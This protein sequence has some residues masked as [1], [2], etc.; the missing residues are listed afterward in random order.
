M[1][2]ALERGVGVPGRG[3]LEY[4]E[5]G[6]GVPRRGGLEYLGLQYPI[7]LMLHGMHNGT[8]AVFQDG[9]F[10]DCFIDYS[11][12]CVFYALLAKWYI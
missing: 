9:Y 2:L 5:G 10:S 1:L 12:S 8:T 3:G 7:V 11:Y 4:L 6:V